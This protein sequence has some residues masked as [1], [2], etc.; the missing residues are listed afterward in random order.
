[1]GCEAVVASEHH[2]DITTDLNAHFP[3]QR[4]PVVLAGDF[5]GQGGMSG[6][7]SAEMPEQ[8][9]QAEILTSCEYV[10]RVTPQLPFCRSY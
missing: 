9:R 8:K 2:L 1:M 4:E 5:G 10:Y 6:H 7:S 3:Q